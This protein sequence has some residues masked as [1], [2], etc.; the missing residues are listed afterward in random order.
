MSSRVLLTL[1]MIVKNEALGIAHT[2]ASA[3]PYVDRWCILD[4][5]STDGTQDLARGAM[6]GVPGEVYEEP[7]VD[8]ATTRNR[9]LD[10]CADTEFIL[11]LDAD[12]EL[13]GGSAL[14]EFLGLARDRVD[15][16]A[17]Y[18]RVEIAAARFDS[19]RVLRS[20]SGWR[21]EGKVH[22]VLTHPE[23]SPPSGRIEGVTVVHRADALSQTRSR[24]RWERDVALL[25]SE[26]AQRP[27]VARPAFYLAMTLFWLGRYEDAVRAFERRIAMGGWGEE[28]FYAKLSRARAAKAAGRPWCEVLVMHLDA[29]ASAPQRAEPLF[30]VAMHY[31]AE[32]NHALALLFAR[33]AYELPLPAQDILFI[34]HEVYEWRAADLVGAHAYWLGERS[35]GERAARQAVAA[36]PNDERLARNLSFYETK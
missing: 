35:L 6:S 21:F 17:H 12:D 36:R 10:L 20:E 2:L 13:C 24:A 30:D 5:G 23:R 4:T 34:E 32:G 1:S 9:A 11:W 22:E 31:D 15:L 33:R 7:F 28:V 14:R 18:V 19:A 3:K 8:F 26:V 16:G 29:H 27:T 25:E